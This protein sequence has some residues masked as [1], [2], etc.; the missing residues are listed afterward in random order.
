MFGFKKKANNQ[1][2]WNQLEDLNQL[3]QLVEQSKEKP[4]LVFKHSTRCS[5]SSMA[6]DRL[7]REWEEETDIIP[8]YL[9]LLAYRPISNEVAHRFNVFHESPQALLIKNGACIYHASH[10]GIRFQ[11]IS[12]NS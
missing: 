5:I 10:N 12:E 8:Y 1:I 2:P 3:D 6:L 4:V 7:E 9:D 11:S